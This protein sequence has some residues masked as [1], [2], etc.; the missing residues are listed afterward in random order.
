MELQQQGFAGYDDPITV[1]LTVQAGDVLGA[2]VFKATDGKS[3]IGHQLDI[4]GRV[5]GEPLLRIDSGGCS[6]TIQVSQLS[7]VDSRRLHLYANIS[8][9]KI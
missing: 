5:N 8:T 9:L 7:T 2:C 4:V 3:L 1:P 6:T